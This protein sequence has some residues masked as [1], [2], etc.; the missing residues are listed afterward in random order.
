MIGKLNLS[1]P[2]VFYC[3]AKQSVNNPQILR[4]PLISCWPIHNVFVVSLWDFFFL[5]SL[6]LGKFTC[7]GNTSTHAYTHVNY[8]LSITTFSNGQ[9]SLRWNSITDISICSTAGFT[10]K[11]WIRDTRSTYRRLIISTFTAAPC[12]GSLNKAELFTVTLLGINHCGALFEG[13][14]HTNHTSWLFFLGVY[15]PFCP[16]LSSPQYSAQLGL[17]LH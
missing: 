15:F 2:N 11:S 13:F 14:G 5:S 8:L 6:Y 1:V 9:L 12:K 7:T 17:M 10:G 16:Q 3:S 4:T